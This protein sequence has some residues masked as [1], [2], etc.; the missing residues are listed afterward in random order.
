MNLIGEFVTNERFFDES[1]IADF[2][3]G[4]LVRVTRYI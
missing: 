3:E 2:R 1:G 4:R